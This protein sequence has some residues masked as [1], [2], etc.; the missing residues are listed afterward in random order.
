MGGKRSVRQLLQTLLVVNTLAVLVVGVIGALAVFE[1]TR[2]VDTLSQ[3][4]SPAQQANARFME[5]MLDSETE[6]RAFLISGEAPQLAD[7][8]AALALAPKVGANL[9]VYAEDHPRMAALAA[10]QDRAAKAW[11][12]DFA[13]EAIRIGGGPGSYRPA[14]YELGVR[15][16]DAIKE[17]NGK[18]TSELQAE[19][20][21]ARAAA[22]DTLNATLALLTVIGL[23]AA[24]GCSLLGWWALRSIRQPLSDLE[25]VVDRLASGERDARPMFAGPAEIRRLGVALNELAEENARARELELHVQQQLVDVDRAKSE[26][27]SNVSH[28]LRTPLTSISGYLELLGETLE[29]TVD[30]SQAE[31]LAITQ[32]NVERLHDLIEDLL[33]LSSAERRPEDVE[34]V[35]LAALIDG[36]VKDLRF[37]AGSRGISISVD[38]GPVEPPPVVL[39]DAAQLHRALLNL[40]SNAVKFSRVGGDVHLDLDASE[41]EVEVRIVDH[42]IGIPSADQLKLGERFYRASNA[43]SAQIPGTGLGVR[44]VQSIVS[45]H[46]GSFALS[47]VEEQGTTAT[48]RLPLESPS[49]DLRSGEQTVAPG[50]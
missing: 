16:F 31:M 29:G 45:N 1:T 49:R 17:V 9:H 24:L 47:S 36:V 35:D 44:M 6:L 28:E 19:V 10:R 40:V 8:R 26:F 22:Q 18:I 20:V 27:V 13:A 43:V 33:A 30:S 23:L 2:T 4:L 7:Y 15:R 38:T 39:G 42:G 5:A 3:E 25:E 46:H 41:D 21:D 12:I 37:S 14:L 48:L 34:R 32:R 50:R 11:I